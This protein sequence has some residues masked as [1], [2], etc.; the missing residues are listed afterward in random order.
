MIVSY[1]AVFAYATVTSD[2]RAVTLTE[3][4]FGVIA[5]AVGAMLYG[6]RSGSGSASVLTVGAGSLVAGGALNVA[7]VLT[8]SGAVDTLSSMLVL[9]GVGCYVYA[10]WRSR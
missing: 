5:V 9:L 2:P 1:F 3:L 4:G 7:A 8:R 6:Q 10:V